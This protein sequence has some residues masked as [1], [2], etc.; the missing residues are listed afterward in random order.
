MGWTE[1]EVKKE[2]CVRGKEGRLV[3]CSKSGDFNIGRGTETTLLRLV[4]PDPR[5]KIPRSG[6]G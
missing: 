1:E 3:L 2:G 5:I 6:Q 4:C